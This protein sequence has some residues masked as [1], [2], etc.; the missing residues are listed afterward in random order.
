MDLSRTDIRPRAI[1]AYLSLIAFH[2]AHV[3]EE[4][5]GRFVVLHR[6]GLAG[7]LAANWALFCLPLGVFYFWLAG[8]RWARAMS[9]LY[10]GLMVLNGLGHNVMTLATGRYFDGY[11]GGFSGLGLIASGALLL[12]ALRPQ[13][14]A[15]GG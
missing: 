3:L 15:E 4:V 14:P 11:A 9:V 8:R 10:A 1:A 7:F 2:A 13:E 5:F 6:L 12:R